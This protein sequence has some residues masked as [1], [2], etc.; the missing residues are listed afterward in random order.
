MK[1]K[2]QDLQG[3]MRESA[4]KIWLAG[5]GALSVAGEEGQKLFK[6]LVEKGQEFETRDHAPVDAVKSATGNVKG[7]VDDFMGRMEETINDKVALALQKVG[8]PTREEIQGL[9]ER[10]DKLMEAINKLNEAK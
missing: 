9:T 10:V 7:K 3:E 6:N 4:H 5:L 8:V 1:E 2:I